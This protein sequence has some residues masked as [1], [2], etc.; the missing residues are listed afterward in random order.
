MRVAVQASA[1][2]LDEPDPALSDIVPIHLMS[3][4]SYHCAFFWKGLQRV[5]WYE[6]G[7][8]DVVFCKQFEQSANS[9]CTREET[10][11]LSICISLRRINEL[12][13]HLLIYRS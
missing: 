11:D 6:P 5:P 7:G 2:E 4:I 1:K 3:C 12:H 8:L 13:T 9:N 10:L